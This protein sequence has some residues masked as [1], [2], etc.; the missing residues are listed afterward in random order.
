MLETKILNKGYC[1]SR[2]PKGFCKEK[3]CARFAKLKKR[4]TG[5]N[6]GKTEQQVVNNCFGALLQL[7]SKNSEQVEA[8]QLYKAYC[9]N[10]SDQKDDR[11]ILHE[12]FRGADRICFLDNMSQLLIFLATGG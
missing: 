7:K 11:V 8:S 4:K 2:F 6:L 9:Q 1:F 12:F 3:A 10:N 5:Q